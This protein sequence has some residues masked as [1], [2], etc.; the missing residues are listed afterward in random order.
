MLSPRRV[1]PS[2]LG[3]LTLL[4]VLGSTIGVAHATAPAQGGACTTNNTAS[5]DATGNNLICVSSVWQYPSYAF[6]SVAASAGASCSGSPAGAMRY[7][8]TSQSMEYCNGTNWMQ[9]AQVQGTAPPTAP[10]G[11]GYFVMSGTTWDSNLGTLAGADSKCLTELSVTYTSWA[12]YSTANSNGQLV[13]SKV[14]AFLCNSASCNNLM[15]LTTYYFAN[16]SSSGAGGAS[17]T[18]DSNGNGPNDSANWSAANRF[19]GSYTWW[20]ERGLTS[21]TVWTSTTSGYGSGNT[22]GNWDTTSDYHTPSLGNTGYSTSARW[23]SA[24][25]PNCSNL[26]NLICFVNP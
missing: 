15:P 6:K 22:C 12:G 8:S 7:N 11:S 21:N 10:A 5:P 26:Y 23:L 2:I 20:S 18:T 17:F 4:A 13:S 24:G 16:A 19:S 25:A 3:V 9:A 1:A 14:H